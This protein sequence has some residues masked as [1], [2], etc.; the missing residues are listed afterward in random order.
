MENGARFSL[1]TSNDDNH[2]E[3]LM[4]KEA[5]PEPIKID[6]TSQKFSKSISWD[7]IPETNKGTLF[8]LHLKKN[9]EY[10]LN[11]AVYL[12]SKAG[13]ITLTIRDED[14]QNEF[15]KYFDYPADGIKSTHSN[16]IFNLMA[17]SE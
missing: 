5:Q 9:G 4:R 16:F 13:V 15:K 6:F 7:K 14:T 12:N 11:S 2:W 10:V 3:I 8:S 17:Q 1:E